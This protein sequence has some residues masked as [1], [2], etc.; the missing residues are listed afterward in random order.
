MMSL[1]TFFLLFIRLSWISSSVGFG[2]LRFILYSLIE[3]RI[4]L[5]TLLIAQKTIPARSIPAANL[6]ITI[7]LNLF[8]YT[9]HSHIYFKLVT[10]MCNDSLYIVLMIIFIRALVSYLFVK[11]L[12]MKWQNIMAS[13][14]VL[15][16]A[17]HSKTIPYLRTPAIAACARGIRPPHLLCTH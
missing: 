17:I 4:Q 1:R 5:K 14:H 6:R 9:K 12:R 8:V 13:V 3:P 16:C 2:R 15:R 10:V 11:W 7:I